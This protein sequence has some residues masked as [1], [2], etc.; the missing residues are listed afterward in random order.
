M[1]IIRLC[2]QKAQCTRSLSRIR[3]Q[4]DL[5]RLID[6]YQACQSF[7]EENQS[8]THFLKY[9]MKS[10]AVDMLGCSVFLQASPIDLNADC[11]LRFLAYTQEVTILIQEYM[12]PFRNVPVVFCPYSEIEERKI[13]ITK[14][15]QFVLVLNN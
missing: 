8:L 15:M 3:I 10:E 2:L 7:G 12:F 5:P 14:E 9:Q 1:F 4:S 11:I 13:N 6:Y